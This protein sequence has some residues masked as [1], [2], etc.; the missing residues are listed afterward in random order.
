MSEVEAYAVEVCGVVFDVC[1]EECVVG[2][3]CELFQAFVCEVFVWF[4][5]F[6]GVFVEA[7][8]TGC[9][10]DEEEC[11]LC[12]LQLYLSVWQGLCFAVLCDDVYDGAEVY[13]AIGVVVV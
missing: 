11:F 3:L 8:E 10:D 1:F 4:S 6:R 2:F 5:F 12:V 13:A 9:V 7:V